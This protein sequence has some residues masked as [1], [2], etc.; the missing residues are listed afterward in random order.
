MIAATAR[1]LERYFNLRFD[2][3]VTYLNRL[4]VT[5][6][7]LAFILL[8]TLIV[9]FEDVT[10]GGT[11]LSGLRAG[12]I[13]PSDIFAPESRTYASQ[14]L[15][16]QRREAAAANVAPIYAPPNPEI[17]RQQTDLAVRILEFI[18][19]VRRASFDTTEQKI[20][21]IEEI[22]ALALDRDTIRQILELDN[23]T[24]QDISDQVV[25][26]LERVMRTDI[27][28][29]NLS[30]VRDQIPNQVGV[31]FSEIEAQIIIAIVGDLIRPNSFP[32]E[33]A[34]QAAREAAAAGVPDET[35]SFERG[36]IVISG[37][38]RVGPAD[39]EALQ[40]LGL[41]RS[42][43]R[44]V[45]GIIEALLG[46]TVVL[47]VIGLYISRFEPSLLYREPRLLTLLA[48]I[49]LF[50]LMGA[51]FGLNGEFYIYPTSALALIYVAIH[52]AHSAVIGTL[53]LAFLVG[54]MASNSLEFTTLVAVGGVI[55]GLTLR[56]SE[57]LNS[58]FFAGLMVA[59]S[60]IAVATLFNLGVA[61][62]INASNLA[63]LVVY[64]LLNGILTAAAAMA[65]MY[66]VTLLFNLPT[67]L[68]LVELSQ[69][70]QPLLQRLLREAPGTYQHSLQ[71]GNLSEQAANAIGANA[72]LTHV[73]ALYHDIG[74]ML[75]PAFFTENQR[76]IGN[77]H[78][79]LNDPYRSADIIIGH[80]TG[81]D[82]MAKQHRLPNRIRDF[83]REH[84]GTSEVFVFYQQALILAGDDE[85]MVDPDD[86]RYPGPRPQSRET[87][88]MMLADTCE[89]A[90]RSRQPKNNQEIE[91]TV[92]TVIDGKRRAGQLDE[93][94]LT[95]ND[96]KVI[97][98]IFIDMLQAMFHPR[99][100]YTEAIAKARQAHED[101]AAE[102][103]AATSPPPAAAPEAAPAKTTAPRPESPEPAS[104]PEQ[105][106]TPP[107]A[108]RQE[109]R[110]ALPATT[111][112]PAPASSPRTDDDAP[113]PEVP[114]LR[115]APETRQAS[116]AYNNGDDNERHDDPAPDAT[117][118]DAT[119]SDAAGTGSETE[120]RADTAAA[121]SDSDDAPRRKAKSRQGKDKGQASQ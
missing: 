80:V 119:E 116:L 26:V 70:N 56:R 41:L 29:S 62:N 53:G 71:V 85:S 91:E 30:S 47:V 96:L 117:A 21:D 25:A 83:I 8:A 12:D 5:L 40:Q 79:S 105:P 23:E 60:N 50:V 11:G 111:P 97:H 66:I 33:A 87:G 57:R 95:L 22:T 14:V 86:F 58:Y 112:K 69:P 68:K 44:R 113:L 109:E 19:N 92:R 48:A 17:A 110:P 75:N 94:G 27:R 6:A 24:W 65:G 104:K 39:F 16:E 31:R 52:G 114:R 32:D 103:A 55:G 101:E 72:E 121:S 51:R 120:D 15:T 98:D 108:P 88:I 36:Q 99:I 20:R 1:L 74:K 77:P 2:L 34:T 54:L 37:G 7:A 106:A 90:V 102:S 43:D 67:A 100:N 89:A 42:D 118:P 35:R 93:S 46:S 59:I 38:T 82:E 10:E 28:E 9:A 18:D 4:V 78:D 64:S 81:G 45:Q 49:F 13:A 73:A 61:D 107:A 76:D 84:H 63:L 115:R 3:A